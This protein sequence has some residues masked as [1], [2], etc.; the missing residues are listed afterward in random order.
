MCGF[1]R[2]TLC[3]KMCVY[4]RKQTCRWSSDCSWRIMFVLTQAFVKVICGPCQSPTCLVK[5]LPIEQISDLTFI[6]G[7]TINVQMLPGNSAVFNLAL[8]FWGD[9]ELLH[10]FTWG[11]QLNYVD[12]SNQQTII[13]DLCDYYL[14]DKKWYGL[15]DK[16][17]A[18]TNWQCYNCTK[19]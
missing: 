10:T 9:I 7:Q 6:T 14:M 17:Y 19:R 1:I 2:N 4:F 11:Y 15:L 5:F 13:M 3:F 18:Y 16:L 12:V 8:S